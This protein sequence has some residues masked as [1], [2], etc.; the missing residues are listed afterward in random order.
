M[1]FSKHEI[2]LPIS[3]NTAW[4]LTGF[5]LTIIALAIS[6]VVFSGDSPQLWQALMSVLFGMSGFGILCIQLIEYLEKRNFSF[7]IKCKC[8][9][10]VEEQND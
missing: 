10:N 4:W 7:S 6:I 1:F 9:E 8:D 3:C 2:I 5:I